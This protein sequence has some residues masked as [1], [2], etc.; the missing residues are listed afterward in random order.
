M[1]LKRVKKKSS[2]GFPVEKT[3]LA[4]DFYSMKVM[5]NDLSV[6]SIY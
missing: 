4:I 5:F 3:A 2:A 1:P 6:I